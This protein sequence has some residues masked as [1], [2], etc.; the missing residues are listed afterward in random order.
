MPGTMD[1]IRL[2]T[3][4]RALRQRLLWRQD[5]LAQRAGISQD[6]VSRIERGQIDRMPLRNVRA[7]AHELQAE[8]VV[9]LRWRGP[10]LDR[11]IDEGHAA[12]GGTMVRLLT[13]AGWQVRT[14]VSYSIF[15]ERGSIDIVAWHA[16]TRTLLVIEVKTDLVSLEETLRKH[17]EKVRLA[18]G[19]SERQ[20][21]WRP[22]SVGRLLVLPDNSTSRRR[23]SRHSAVIRTVYPLVG[24]PARA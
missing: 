9:H 10:E 17:D 11:L 20:F 16:P 6:V 23:I 1:D 24:G 14:E 19:M 5:D 15:G 7:V 3:R 8:V 13:A 22:T 21:G 18:P 2:G 4:L 12:L